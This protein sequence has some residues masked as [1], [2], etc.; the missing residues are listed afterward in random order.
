MPVDLSN[1]LTCL[2]LREIGADTYEGDNLELDYHRVFGGQVLAQSVLA[3]GAA[4]R[5]DL[6]LKSLTQRFPREGGVETPLRYQVDRRQEGRS[7]ASYDVSADQQG[8]LVSVGAASLH[9]PESG[10]EWQAAAPATTPEEADPAPLDMVPW[11]VRVVGGVD[12]G[13]PAAQPPV[14]RFWMR[15]PT[16]EADDEWTHQALLAYATDLTVIGTGLLPIE[17]VSQNGTGSVF[18]SAVTTHSLWFHRPVRMDAWVLVD[19][20]SPIVSGGRVFGRGDVWTA[21]GDLVASFAQ[22]AMVRVLPPR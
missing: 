15:I 13:A 10:Y 5:P 11:E 6:R 8:R 4:A 14:Y 20:H 12:L 22:E 19:Q 7:F 18:H 16:L 2:R 1:L 21:T 3:L 9:V 17:G